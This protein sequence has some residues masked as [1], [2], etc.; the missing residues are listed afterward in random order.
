MIYYSF[1]IVKSVFFIKWSCGSPWLFWLLSLDWL[2]NFEHAIRSPLNMCFKNVNN[3]EFDLLWIPHLYNSNIESWNDRADNKHI[4]PSRV[5]IVH[6]SAT[7]PRL[8]HKDVWVLCSHFHYCRHVV[9]NGHQKN[10]ID[11]DIALW[12]DPNI[13]TILISLINIVERVHVST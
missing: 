13:D 5:E 12:C 8:V 9:M 10:K 2:T 4:G 1:S 7:R 11:N 3:V 6:N